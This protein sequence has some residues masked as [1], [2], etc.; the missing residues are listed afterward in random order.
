MDCIIHSHGWHLQFVTRRQSG[1]ESWAE[2]KRH[3]K[4][5]K[6]VQFVFRGGDIGN[7]YEPNIFHASSL[8]TCHYHGW[9]QLFEMYAVA[10]SCEASVCI[11]NRSCSCGCVKPSFPVVLAVV[12]SLKSSF[13]LAVA[14]VDDL[15]PEVAPVVVPSYNPKFAVA[16]AVVP[17]W[18]S[19]LQL[20][21]QLD[22][23]CSCA[24]SYGCDVKWYRSCGCSL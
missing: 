1:W 14:V 23:G 3:K 11:Y 24:C 20:H 17:G 8:T 12:P 19:S 16:L 21:L 6:F 13:V 2:L 9:G 7:K 15:Y 4:Y 22:T 5:L 10:C 18:N